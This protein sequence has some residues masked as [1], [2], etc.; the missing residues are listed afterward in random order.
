MLFILK[1]FLH[2]SIGSLGLAVWPLKVTS[3]IQKKDLLFVITCKLLFYE[4]LIGHVCNLI[5]LRKNNY[6]NN[7]TFLYIYTSLNKFRE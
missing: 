2:Y 1:Y 6:Y 4:A 3:T 5:F 7:N